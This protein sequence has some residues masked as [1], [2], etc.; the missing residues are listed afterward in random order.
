MP[1][2]SR[3]QK[4]AAGARWFINQ[5]G[6]DSR[7]IHELHR[8][9]AAARAWRVPLIG[10]VYVLNPGVA[11]VFRA[12]RIPGS[13]LSDEL[14]AVCERQGL[15]RQGQGLLP[16]ARRQA[17]RH[18]SRAGLSR[19]L[20]RRRAH[21]GGG[22]A[23][24]GDRARL[25]AG[26]LEA[27]RP[28]NPL[29]AAGGVFRFRRGSRHR[30]RRPRAPAPGLRRLAAR[31]PGHAQRHLQLPVLQVHPRAHVHARPGPLESRRE[32]E[33]GGQGSAAGPGLA[34]GPSS[35]SASA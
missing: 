17:G 23:R 24:A 16:R 27:V 26:R 3:E 1:Q 6:Y 34:C 11:K 12:Q 10:N 4:I 33:R 21:G 19:R 20:P 8:L 7:K 13:C 28:R 2:L 9:A 25:R 22:P 29:L 5:I 14:A 35:T 32:T 18:L 15:A 30:P 31:A